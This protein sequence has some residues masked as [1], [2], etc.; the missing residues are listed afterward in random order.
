MRII[1]DLQDSVLDEQ[2]RM[3]FGEYLMHKV[4]AYTGTPPDVTFYEEDEAL[5]DVDDAIENALCAHFPQVDVLCSC[6]ARNNMDGDVLHGHR[7]GAVSAAVHV[8]L[9]ELKLIGAG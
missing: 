8:A 9:A 3:V 1:I 7:L 6:G 2:Q 4:V 5:E